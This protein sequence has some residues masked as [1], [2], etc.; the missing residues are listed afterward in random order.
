MA[1]GCTHEEASF[2]CLDD[3]NN[4]SILLDKDNDLKEDIPH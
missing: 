1:S 2:V 3:L 4:I